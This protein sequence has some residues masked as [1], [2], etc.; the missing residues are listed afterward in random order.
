MSPY[1]QTSSPLTVSATGDSRLDNVTLY[2]RWS[3]DNS[4]WNGG[5]NEIYDGV[6][7]NTSN[8]DGIADKGVETNFSN[9]K[10]TTRDGKL[11]I[12]QEQNTGTAA[13]NEWLSC[14]ALG[15]TYPGWTRVGTTPYVGAIDYP[16][17]YV[18]TATNNAQIGWFDFPSTTLTGALIVNISIYCRNVDGAGDDGADVYVDYTGSG[19]GTNVGRVGQHTAWQYDTINL[20]THTISEVDNLRLYLYYMKSGNQNNV[21]I[22]HIRIGVNQPPAPNYQLDFEYQWTTAVYNRVNKKVCVY[23]ASHTGGTENLLVNYWNGSIWSSLGTITTTGWSNFTA[24][25]LISSSYTIQ[26]KGATESGDTVK[27]IWNIDVIMLHTWNTTGGGTSGNWYDVNWIYRKKINITG[28][29]GAGP[30]YQVLLNIGET[31]GVSGTNF[32]LGGHSSNFPSGKNIGGDLRFINKSGTTS[33]D[34]WVESVSGT[35]PNR[36]AKIWVEVK[37]SLN[38]STS[39]YCYYGNP[40]ASNASNGTHTFLVFDDFSGTSLNTNIWTNKNVDSTTFSN[41][42]MTTSVNNKDPTKLIATTAPTGDNIAIRAYFRTT[43]GSDSDQRMGVG[44]KT[45]TSDGYGY[46]YVLHNFQSMNAIQF[47]NDWVA[48]GPTPETIW[49]K[50]TWYIFEISH[51]GTNVRARRD[52]GSWKTWSTSGNTGYPAL[53]TGGYHETCTGEWDWALVR[54]C[55]ATEPSYS[56]AGVEET[57]NSTGSGVGHN[58]IIYT[59]D[60]NPDL[61]SPWSWSFN[62]PKGVGYYEFYSIGRYAGTIE[63]APVSA[64]ARCQKT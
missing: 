58:W 30:N 16:T 36:L 63:S 53:N 38:S 10:N 7:S 54:K 57:Y 46:N 26:L 23:V 14:N 31:S 25:G 52:D 21:F 60:T 20:G 59:G 49:S 61:N 12:L 64:D 35:A 4:S 62:F 40:S 15:I 37:D 28:Q 47:L 39:I 22:D 24:T 56:S 44:I 18:Y 27:D 51:D 6:D 1:V 32:N 41:G 11:M 34:F 8:V 33:L 2:Y 43:G 50:N 9:A 5:S 29:A 3:D 17:N 42:I 13:V 19:L 48:W 55:L 45:R